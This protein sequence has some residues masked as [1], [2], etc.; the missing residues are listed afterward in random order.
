MSDKCKACGFDAGQWHD[1]YSL[2]TD[3]V[4]RLQARIDAAEAEN[5]RLQA[6]KERLREQTADYQSTAVK[7]VEGKNAQLARERNAQESLVKRIKRLQAQLDAVRALTD[8]WRTPRLDWHE[9]YIRASNDCADELEA[10]LKESS[11]E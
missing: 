2:A 4:G 3:E 5:E 10:A 8:D 9:A 6:E 7:I 11:N 1:S